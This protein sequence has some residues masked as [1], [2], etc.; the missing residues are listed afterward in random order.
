MPISEE[1]TAAEALRCLHCRAPLASDPLGLRCRECQRIYPIVA[2]IPI[3]VTEPIEYLRS[4]V[5]LLNRAARNA[6]RRGAMLDKTG[7]D[8]GLTKATIDRHRDFIDAEL[9]RI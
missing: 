5:A 2:G 9:A 1:L 8:P 4:E 6:K 3:L 7:R